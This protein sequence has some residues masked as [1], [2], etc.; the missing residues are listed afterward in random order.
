MNTQTKSTKN[1]QRTEAIAHL[2]TILK[3]GK[4][5]FTILRHRSASGMSRSISLVTVH[6]GEL[7]DITFW[8]GRAMGYTVDQNNEGLKVQGCGMDMGFELV[9]NLG[10]TLF[11]RGFVPAKAGQRYGRN[12]TDANLVDQDGGYALQHSWL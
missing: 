9:Y 7:R 12:G 2:K 6:K 1:T 11:P 10:R 8:A 3:P 5:V 4:K